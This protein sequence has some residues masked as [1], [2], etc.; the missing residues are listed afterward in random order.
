MWI[1]CSRYW[2]FMTAYV[3]CGLQSD[4]TLPRKRSLPKPQRSLHCQ[5]N[6]GYTDD[7][8]TTCTDIDECASTLGVCDGNATC[9]NTIPDFDCTCKNDYAG[10]KGKTCTDN[11]RVQQ[12]N[13]CNSKAECT[14]RVP[15]FSCACNSGFHGDS[16]TLCRQRMPNLCVHNCDANANCTNQSPGFQC[17]CTYRFSDNGTSCFDINECTT[18]HCHA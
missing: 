6:R 7:G 17:G 8:L 12:C 16:T 1:K 2:Y 11:W 5:C 4:L 13:N 15:G 18:M 14:N 3:F 9:R 10:G